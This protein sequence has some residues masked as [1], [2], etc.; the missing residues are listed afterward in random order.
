MWVDGNLGFQ[1]GQ[2][3]MLEV[4]LDASP[5]TLRFFV[6]NREQPVYATNIPQSIK[7]AVCNLSVLLLF[8]SLQ[9]SSFMEGTSFTLS[10][11][12]VAECAGR[13]L[14]NSKAKRWGTQWSRFNLTT[15]KWE[16]IE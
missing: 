7:F 2:T 8:I 14:P 9:V 16:E 6:D 13:G 5:H 15:Q 10:L 1:E 4:N 12:E 11:R 3:V